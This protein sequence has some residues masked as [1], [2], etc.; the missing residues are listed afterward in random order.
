MVCCRQ[1]TPISENMLHNAILL[2]RQ[3]QYIHIPCTASSVVRIKVGADRSLLAV[4]FTHMEGT[5]TFIQR[6]QVFLTK[7]EELNTSLLR[8]NFDVRTQLQTTTPS[9][10]TIYYR[11]ILG[12]T[13]KKL[14]IAMVL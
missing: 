7:I 4:Q 10:C 8:D 6:L 1:R 9:V 3:W 5:S 2:S 11:L 14:Y 12:L 13:K